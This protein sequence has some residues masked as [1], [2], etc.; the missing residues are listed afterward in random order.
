MTVVLALMAYAVAVAVLTPRWLRRSAWTRGTPRLGIL[1]WQASVGA[2]L[3]SLVLLAVAAALPVGQVSFDVGHLLHACSAVLRSRYRF[4]DAPRSAVVAGAVAAAVTVLLARAFVLRAVALV[5]QRSRQR[6]MIDVL[7]CDLTEDGARVVE[8]HVPLAYCIPGRGGRIVLTSAAVNA[9][10]AEQL[11]AVIA[12]ERAHLQGTPRP[13]AFRRRGRQGGLPVGVV[14][15]HGRAADRRA[16]RDARRRPGRPPGRGAAAGFRAGG[17]GFQGRAARRARSQLEDDAGTGHAP[18]AG[19]LQ[20]RAVASGV[21][22][23]CL[24]WA[25]AGPVGHRRPSRLGRQGRLLSGATALR[26]AAGDG[27]KGSGRLGLSPSGQ[28]PASATS[29]NAPEV[30]GPLLPVG[31]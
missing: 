9:L 27:S 13:R 17:H 8:H 29:I 10:D 4:G 6:C 19:P 30:A 26:H 12:H 20:P 5:G 18:G 15:P 14:L 7:A 31:R 2:V 16:C 3:G 24:R 22:A 11:E 21:G 25:A 1:A 23:D 28:A